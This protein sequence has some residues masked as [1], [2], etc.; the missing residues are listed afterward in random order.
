MSKRD[1]ISGTWSANGNTGDLIISYSGRRVV[2]FYAYQS[3]SGTKAK[4]LIIEDSNKSGSYESTDIIF[5][6][7]S[8]KAEYVRSGKIPVV[9]SGAFVAD[10]TTGRFKLLYEGTKY[11]TGSIYDPS[12]YF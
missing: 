10:A 2:G 12:E 11:A 9:A 4:G 7:F 1:L 5:G 8:A 6:G 3:I